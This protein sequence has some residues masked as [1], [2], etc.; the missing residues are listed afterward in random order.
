M[1]RT[2]PRPL[3]LLLA[4]FVSL[5]GCAATRRSNA[6]REAVLATAQAF[7]DA[8]RARDPDAAARTV[9]PDGVFVSTRL[10]N[11]K[12][13]EKHF[14]NREWV[15]KLPSEHTVLLE[16]FTGEPTVLVDGDVAVVW[17]AYFFHVDGQLSHTGVDAFNLVRTDAGWR[18]SGGAYSVVRPAP[19]PAPA[20][21]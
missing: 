16:A 21:N 11:G 19:P 18:I 1:K 4:V 17:A 8:M 5:C 15:E 9:L 20:R 13:V 3:P 14:T 2:F 6:D 12:R 7:F 10:E